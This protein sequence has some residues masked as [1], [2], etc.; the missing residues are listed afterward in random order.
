MANRRRNQVFPIKC[1]IKKNE[2]VLN[3]KISAMNAVGFVCD[4]GDGIIRPGEICMANFEM[5]LVQ[6][7]VEVPVIAFKISDKVTSGIL[8][9][10][11]A[12]KEHVVEFHFKNASPDFKNALSA[13]FI[14]YNSLRN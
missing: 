2:T 13:F 3:G 9:Q 6:K 8:S 12:Q 5:P 1:Q 4:I 7:F 14:D 10:G 11:K